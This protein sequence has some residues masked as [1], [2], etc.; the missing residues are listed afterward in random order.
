MIKDSGDKKFRYLIVHKPDRF[1][2]DKYASVIYKRKLRANG[3]SVLS[4]TE[5]LDDSH[6]ALILESVIEGMAQYYTARTQH[7]R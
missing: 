2:R 3:V 1:S 5:N 6:E 4:V 7:V